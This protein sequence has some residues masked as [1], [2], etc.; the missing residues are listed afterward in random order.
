MRRL[1]IPLFTFLLL[2][3]VHAEEHPV[4]D[5]GPQWNS[6]SPGVFERAR[7]DGK[8]VL[9]DLV[10]DWCAFCEKMD[11]ITYRDPAVLDAIERD[12]I[13]VRADPEKVPNLPPRFADYGRPSTVFLTPDGAEVLNKQGYLKPQWMLWML[14]AVAAQSASEVSD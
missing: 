9:V 5:S 6:W 10:A 8:L 3:V 12:Y 1:T 14:Q 4:I 13:A 2:S 7:R 11:A